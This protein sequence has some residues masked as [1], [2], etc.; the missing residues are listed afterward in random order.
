[1]K[2]TRGHSEISIG[3]EIG[4]SLLLM[5]MSADVGGQPNSPP[6]QTLILGTKEAPLQIF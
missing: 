6:P 1:M 4:F 2:L 3:L 5:A